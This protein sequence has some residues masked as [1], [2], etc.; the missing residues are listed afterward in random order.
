MWRDADWVS[1]EREARDM[2][3]GRLS[4][5]EEGVLDA[6]WLSMDEVVGSFIRDYWGLLD[7]DDGDGGGRDGR[8]KQI[9]RAHV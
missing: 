6:D 7:D 8:E 1:K 9:G 2:L 5:E 3:G 4:W